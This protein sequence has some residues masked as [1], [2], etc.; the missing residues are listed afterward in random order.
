M[1]RFFKSDNQSS[2]FKVDFASFLAG[3]GTGQAIVSIDAF[4]TI[5]GDV[6]LGTGSKA[7]VLTDANTAIVFYVSGG[8]SGTET[9]FEILYTISNGDQFDCRVFFTVTDSTN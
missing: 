6:A 7:P 5:S 1:I 9:I 3:E 2:R 4:A 8:T